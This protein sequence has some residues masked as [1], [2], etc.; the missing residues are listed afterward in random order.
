MK[1]G[2]TQ[3]LENC[4]AR[5][6]CSKIVT[7]LSKMYSQSGLKHSKSRKKT[8]QFFSA[9]FTLIELLV[10]IA[11]IGLLS[12][13]IFASLGAVRA[14]S[15]DARRKVDLRQVV[16]ALEFYYDKY[17][18]Y[19]TSA[20]KDSGSGVFNIFNSLCQQAN[21][22]QFIAS[23]PHDPKYPNVNCY[24]AEY[25]YISDSFRSPGALGTEYVIYATLEDQSTSNLNPVPR[26][27]DY[28]MVHT[29]P[30]SGYGIPNYR[31]GSHNNY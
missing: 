7:N 17:G 8:M 4:I 10:V 21:F 1:K 19:P 27:A 9:G 22:M 3:S 24:N 6:F 16:N 15:R 30:C 2:F 25:V 29:W 18:G 13:V 31:S 5:V 14:K 26:S 20:W 28:D 11:I 23:C 12:S